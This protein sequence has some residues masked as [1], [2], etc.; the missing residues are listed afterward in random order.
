MRRSGAE[1][2]SSVPA[3]PAPTGASAR[4][5]SE[6]VGR[7]VQ[8]MTR[9]A[10]TSAG[11]TLPRGRTISASASDRPSIAVI[12]PVITRSSPLS[13]SRRRSSRATLRRK[14]RSWRKTAEGHRLLEID[15]GGRDH[16][17]VDRPARA[18]ETKDRASDA[19]LTD[20]QP[21]LSVVAGA[22]NQFYLLYIA[23]GLR[24]TLASVSRRMAR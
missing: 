2:G 22:H 7:P 8:L 11:S 15:V 23:Q 17:H 6:L 10:R 4:L 1:T 19:R 9:S 3:E 13:R 21:K 24:P 12:R 20:I 5:C 14:K 16:A 18:A